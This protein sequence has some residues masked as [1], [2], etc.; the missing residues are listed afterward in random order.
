[1][2]LPVRLSACDRAP[3]GGPRDPAA[4]LDV[5]ASSVGGGGGGLRPRDPSAGSLA[6]G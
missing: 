6:A 2:R 5:A 4:A 3:G 1:M